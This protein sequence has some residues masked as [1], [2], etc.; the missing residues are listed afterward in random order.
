MSRLIFQNQNTVKNLLNVLR[1]TLIIYPIFRHARKWKGPVK[2]FFEYKYF[3]FLNYYYVMKIAHIPNSVVDTQHENDLRR[4]KW[5]IFHFIPR[6]NQLKKIRIN[7]FVEIQKT[8]HNDVLIISYGNISIYDITVKCL[9]VVIRIF[10]ISKSITNARRI[11][12]FD[13]GN[14]SSYTH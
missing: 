14:I 11:S 7:N 13:N 1:T 10:I 9:A 4:E 8:I 5:K 6:V 3:F 2:S 12:Y